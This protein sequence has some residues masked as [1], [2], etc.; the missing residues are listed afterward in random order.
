MEPKLFF[1]IDSHFV[2][3]FLAKSIQEK[4]NCKIYSCFEITD[5]P[6]KY[7]EKQNL[8]NFEQYWFFFDHIKKSDEKPD[9]EYLKKFEDKYKINLWLIA[10]NDRFFYRYNPF[11]NFST[12]EKLKILEQECKFFEK[13]IDE[14]KP[15]FL[16]SYTSHQQQNDLFYQICKAKKINILWF[17]PTH[18]GNSWVLTDRFDRFESF[19]TDYFETKNIEKIVDYE[20]Y[21]QERDKFRTQKVMKSKY[22]KSKLDYVKAAIHFLLSENTN[23]N[24]HFTYYGRSKFKVLQKM[25][26]YELKRNSRKNYMDNN[27]KKNINFNEKF[28]YFPLHQEIERN[29]L[30]GAPF[31]INQVEIVKQIAQSLPIGYKLLVKDHTVMESRGWRSISEMKKL[32]EMSNVEVIHPEM[33]SYE[34]FPKCSLVITIGGT[35]SIEAAFFNK[36]SISFRKVG[37]VKLPSIRVI[38]NPHE[39]PNAIR[40]SL[41]VKVNPDDVSRFLS[42]THHNSFHFDFFGVMTDFMN[43]FNF[44]GFLADTELPEEDMKK[45]FESNKEK[46][47]FLALEHI[48]EIEKLMVKNDV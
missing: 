42:I 20:Q 8:V 23:V 31:H 30:L 39:L 14:S 27:L 46:F 16:I 22:Q 26:D 28:V 21:L 34:I 7:F 18:V 1:W 43:K 32:M 17:T 41:K 4:I 48:K 40:E 12:T 9:L 13:I 44:G 3:Y 35:S 11:Y 6:K 15:D 19:D 45:F 33:D 37:H 5:K 10:F 36:P 24:T 25:I 47:D 2:H 38:E 29:L